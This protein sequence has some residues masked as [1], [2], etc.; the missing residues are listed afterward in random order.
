MILI[1]GKPA[2]RKIRDT[3]DP[4]ATLYL[5]NHAGRWRRVRYDMTSPAM[6]AAAKYV[7]VSGKPVTVTFEETTV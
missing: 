3:T 2:P 1:D 5:V 4:D 7:I 6:Y